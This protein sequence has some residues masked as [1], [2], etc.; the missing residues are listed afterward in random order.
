M[1]AVGLAVALGLGTQ[2][3]VAAAADD[4]YLVAPAANPDLPATCGLDV[5]IA[6]D[7][8]YSIKNAGRLQ[9]M[10]DAARALVGAFAD[11]NTRVGIVT[12]SATAKA[13]VPLTYATS[14]SVTS[15]GVHGQ[16][17]NGY[18]SGAGT[19]WQ[20]GLRKV[21][22]EFASARA[23]AGK[24]AIVI[25]DGAPT[26][27]TDSNGQTVDTHGGKHTPQSVDA[28]TTVAND[29][30]QHG[31]HMLAIGTGKATS[32]AATDQR[33]QT[34][35]ERISGPDSVPPNAF[36]A[37]KTDLVLQDIV[38]QSNLNVLVSQFRTFASQALAKSGC[39]FLAVTPSPSKL[40]YG[41]RAV[42]VNARLT[43]GGGTAISGA[44][45]K[46]MTRIGSKPWADL[47]TRTT[48]ASGRVSIA[49]TT[50][51]NR[52]FMASFAGGGGQNA[53]SSAA[54]GVTVAP[55]VTRSVSKRRLG[56]SAMLLHFSGTVTPKKAVKRAFLQKRLHG[57]WQTLA[58]TKLSRGHYSFTRTVTGKSKWRIYVKASKKFGAGHSK[59]VKV[60]V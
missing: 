54:V 42:T 17:I 52:Q 1:T 35:L 11:K 38:P 14:Q 31:V 22:S 23:G 2:A 12:F 20:D 13:V 55:K 28:A 18:K 53:V 33:Y 49:T 8:S 48:D 16:A 19:D 29:L 44:Q 26:Q 60:R 24:L 15:T 32:N 47:G 43:S 51:R 30:K 10:R 58:K 36:N 46:L 50:K 25:S 5:V 56:R 40:T 3:G 6:I 59:R 37:A 34:A 4:P 21:S 39:S 7:A 41:N 45:V 9:P 57:T 27:Y